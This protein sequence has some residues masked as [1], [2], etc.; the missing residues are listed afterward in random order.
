MLFGEVRGALGAAAPENQRGNPGA[1][2]KGHEARG[3]TKVNNHR[4]VERKGCRLAQG[5]FLYNSNRTQTE[6]TSGH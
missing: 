4:A 2:A 6:T 3:T 1:T 5:V